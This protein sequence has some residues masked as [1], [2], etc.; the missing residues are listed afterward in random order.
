[1]PWLR[2]SALASRPWIRLLIS[3]LISEGLSC[4]IRS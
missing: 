2:T 4:I 3:S 1:V